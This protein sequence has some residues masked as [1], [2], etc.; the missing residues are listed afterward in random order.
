MKILVFDTETSG[1][2]DAKK[3]IISDNTIHDLPYIV[4][5]SFMLFDTDTFKY[6]EFDYVIKCPINIPL[7][8]VNIHGITDDISRVRGFEFKDVLDIF[9]ICMNQCDLLIAHNVEF[10]VTMLQIECFRLDCTFNITKPIYCTMKSTTA[11]CRIPQLH[12]RGGIKWPRLSELHEYLFHEQA[13]N[14][15]DSMIDVIICLRCYIK[16]MTDKDVCI[17]IK[18][19]RARF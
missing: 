15:H 19:L 10:D 11:L 1:I 13:N 12:G 4:Q 17:R 7:S 18:K 3:D 5:F 8:A 9:N 14:L 2:V 16:L 6:T